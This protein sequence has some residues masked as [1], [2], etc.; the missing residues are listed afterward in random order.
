GA[1]GTVIEECGGATEDVPVTHQDDLH[2]QPDDGIG[3][4]DRAGEVFLGDFQQRTVFQTAHGGTAWLVIDD[5][6][7]AD[8]VACAAGPH[9]QK[10]TVRLFHHDTDTSCL[11]EIGTCPVVTLGHDHIIDLERLFSLQCVHSSVVS[12]ASRHTVPE[13]G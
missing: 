9:V 3:A 7:L 13:P 6:H 2:D 4:P 12:V 8:D 5:C 11:D 1:P 10:S